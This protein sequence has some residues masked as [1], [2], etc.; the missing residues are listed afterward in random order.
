[1]HKKGPFAHMG[2]EKEPPQPH[3][4][5]ESGRTLIHSHSARPKR[6]LKTSSRKRG[7]RAM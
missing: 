3:G 6:H 4:P 2:H 7:R 1:M 5:R